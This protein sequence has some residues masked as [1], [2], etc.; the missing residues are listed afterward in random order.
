VG[1]ATS[2]KLRAAG[3]TT[4]GRLAE[5]PVEYLIQRWGKI[6]GVLHMF[7]NGK[8]CSPVQRTDHVRSIKS[9]G[10]SATTPRDLRS[11]EDVHLML[12]LLAESIASRM[13]ELS[14]RCTVVEVY[15]RDVELF[16]FTRQRRLCVPTCSSAEIAQVAFDLF[17]KNYRWLKPIRSIGVRGS[18]LIDASS[19][20]QMSLYQDDI[21]RDK[22]ERIDATVDEL[23]MEYG[24][25]SIRRATTMADP[26]LGR[27]NPKDDH[28]VHPVGYFGG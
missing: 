11:N 28:T 13:R 3:I 18:G 8:D 2:R 26:L 14:S 17:Q 9:V 16:S 4:I 10:N 12:L 15:V 24:Y 25:M 6:G 5:T 20:R 1:P 21:K 7:A 23:R 22:W 19:G 27:I